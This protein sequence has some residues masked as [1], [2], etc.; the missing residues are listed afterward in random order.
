[1]YTRT[2]ALSVLFLS[3]V[4]C[5]DWTPFIWALQFGADAHLARNFLSI[6]AD[7][8]VMRLDI[9]SICPTARPAPSHNAH[10]FSMGASGAHR[11]MHG[12]FGLVRK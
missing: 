12:G 1:V 11:G 4:R 3:F 2:L 8:R 6:D 5:D 9:F 7:G 10:C